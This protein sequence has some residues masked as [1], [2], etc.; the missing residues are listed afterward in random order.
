MCV[1]I[2]CVPVLEKQL[3]QKGKLYISQNQNDNYIKPLSGL[4]T[5]I[6]VFPAILQY[7]PTQHLCMHLLFILYSCFLYSK[8]KSF[9]N[10]F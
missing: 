8:G 9:L 10:G 6:Y 2:V 7:A 4:S 1:R 3:I 5:K